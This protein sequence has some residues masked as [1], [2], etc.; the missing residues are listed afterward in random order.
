VT[1]LAWR[2]E[3][4]DELPSTNTELAQRWRDGETAGAVLLADYQ[5]AGKGRRDREWIAPPA[6][7]LLC[8]I[9]LDVQS[10]E[11]ANFVP[12]TAALATK[13]A[14]E[15]LMNISVGLKWP[16]DL[17]VAERKLA[18]VLSEY[19]VAGERQAVVVGLGVN[20]TYSGP[21]KVMA[22]S[23]SDQV[24]SAPAPRVLLEALLEELEHR[25]PLLESDSGRKELRGEYEASLLTLGQVVNVRMNDQTIS[26]FAQGIDKTGQLIVATTSGEVRC[27]VGDV[28]HVRPAEEQPQ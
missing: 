26:G 27:N 17:L 5:S 18:G 14:L 1:T 22:T 7:S 20:L 16:N 19:L 10:P 15:S 21:E 11:S 25:L 24:G 23:V 6:S 12:F 8:S 28:V 4:F 9:L 2:I 3:H 13:S